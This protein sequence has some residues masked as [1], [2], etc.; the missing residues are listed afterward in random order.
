M[1]LNH[2]H[3]FNN[4]NS[5][6]DPI[7]DLLKTLSC[8][9]NIEGKGSLFLSHFQ[10]LSHEKLITTCLQCCMPLMFIDKS[11]AHHKIF[12]AYCIIRTIGLSRFQLISL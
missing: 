3:N 6:T 4:Y 7:I 5:D 12:V 10:I 9:V 8:I 1:K 11:F 2:R